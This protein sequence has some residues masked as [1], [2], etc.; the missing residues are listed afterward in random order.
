MSSK[1]LTVNDAA[2]SPPAYMTRRRDARSRRVDAINRHCLE[3]EAELGLGARGCLYA[4]FQIG[5]VVQKHQDAAPWKGKTEAVEQLAGHPDIRLSKAQLYRYLKLV[6]NLPTVLGIAP[7]IFLTARK[8]QFLNLTNNLSVLQALELISPQKTFNHDD[9]SVLSDVEI[10][11]GEKRPTSKKRE[12]QSAHPDRDDHWTTPPGILR[13]VLKLLGKIDNDPCGAI[14]PALHIAGVTTYTP[15][16]NS[17]LTEKAWDGRLF[18]HPPVSNIAPFLQRAVDA[19]ND[20]RAV[21]AVALIPAEMDAEHM[22]IL[23][24]F[25]KGFFHKRPEFALPAGDPVVPSTPFMAVFIT[26]DRERNIPFAL[27]FGPMADI[28]FPHQF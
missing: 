20:G 27:A 14:A 2:K 24:P 17:L 5:L 3:M 19:I 23:Q 9:N 13:C 7:E 12:R 1:E 10:Q 21:E 15:A 6:K 8:N 28:Y 22:A 4:A 25:A 11:R 26:L 18:L 16:D